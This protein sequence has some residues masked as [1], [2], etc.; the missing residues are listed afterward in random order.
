MHNSA[1]MKRN[2]SVYN[3]VLSPPMALL[4][5]MAVV[6][7]GLGSAEAHPYAS[8]VKNNAGTIQFYLNENADNV[9][10][11]FDNG[12]GTNNLGALTKGLNSF[13]LGGHTNFSIYVYK[14]GTGAPSQI[15]VDT[16]NTVIFN[17]PRGVAVNVNPKSP[18]FGRVYAANAAPGGLT[19]TFKGRGLYL[20]NSDLSDALGRGTN[21][22]GAVFSG[23][24]LSPNRLFVAADDTVYVSDGGPTASTIWQFDPE[25]AVSTNQLLGAAGDT[26]GIAAGI[27][28][29]IAS[30]PCVTGGLAGGN[31]TIF[32]TDATLGPNYNNI[33]RYDIGAGPVPWSNAPMTIANVGLPTYGSTLTQPST[34]L[35][36][37]PDGTKLFATFYRL[38][39]AVPGLQVFDLYGTLLFDSIT[40]LG[41][42]VGSGPD[43]IQGAF[44]VKVSPDNKYVAVANV[45]NQIYVI[46]LTNGVPDI[47]TIFQIPTSPTTGNMRQIGWDAADNI[48]TASSGQGVLRVYSLGQTTTAITGND[49]SGNSGSFQL[50]TPE[51]KASVV[52]NPSFATQRGP[53]SGVFTIT[54]TSP[55]PVDLNQPLRVNFSLGG[56]AT[57]GVYTVSPAGITPATDGSI[58]F[59][60]GQTST[61]ITI[62]PVVDNVSRPTTTVVLSLKAGGAYGTAAPQTATITIENI[63]PQVLFVSGIGAPSMYKRHTTDFA[64]FAISRWGDTNAPAYTASSFSYSGSAVLGTDFTGAGPVTINP[65]ELTVTNTV[66]PLNSGSAYVGNRSVVVGMAD[67]AGYKAGT[68]TAELTIIDSVNPPA[69]VIYSNPLTSTADAANWKITFGNGDAANNPNDYNVDFGYDLSSDPT[70]THGI[71]PPPPSG[72]T[73][74]LR[75]TCNKLFYPGSAG[76]VNLYLTN[77]VLSG[78]YAVRFKM[79]LIQGGNANYSTEG[80]LFGVNHDG[81]QA[82]WWYGSGPLNGG[83]WAS[84]GLWYW[85]S[86]D[87]GGAGAGDFLE[88]TGNGGK[89]P[90]TGWQ[91]IATQPWTAFVNAFKDP[92]VYTTLE[93]GNGGVP[94][95]GTPLNGLNASSWA[96]VE[97]KQVKNVVTLSI[98]K[99]QVFTYANTTSFTNGYLMLGYCDPFGGSGGASVGNPDA[100][101]YF[102]D[103]QVVRLTG[104]LITAINLSNKTNVVVNFTSTDGTDTPA[105]FALQGATA[106]GAQFA[107]ITSATVTQQ[108][109]GVFQAWAISTDKIRFFRIRHK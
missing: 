55:N 89:L 45:N 97:L 13:S 91:Q 23:D 14:L 76:G 71:I 87:P 34:D 88:F 90:N 96:D 67:G 28:G 33:N 8:G 70:F 58:T 46:S 1:P 5:G 48:Y 41:L 4:L 16:D 98:D 85:V 7:S 44:T 84:D 49:A 99:T 25:V 29:R 20:F 22:S 56:S 57:N 92:A 77:Q 59:A 9:G 69:P 60:A 63:G 51:V 82:N 10:V 94:A 66:S 24:T 52:A 12:T 93:G 62:T 53:V 27:H 50:V 37:S 64:S 42:F 35:D 72:A 31:L 32:N 54:R 26:A 81:N 107:D 17:A 39:N 2:G 68:G 15:S 102:S 86:A 79:N 40:S 78:D 75:V 105:S 65:G 61:N 11:S 83:P 30:A 108:L 103:L 100:A 106:I 101:A 109:N 95:N 19:N 18:R 74:A 36:I 73:T 3:A 21:I 47:S 6:L 104:P 43:P 38:N 80:V